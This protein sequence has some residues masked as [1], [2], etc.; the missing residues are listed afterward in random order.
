MMKRNGLVGLGV[1]GWFSLAASFAVLAAEP[2]LTE[3]AGQ[4]PAPEFALTDA[5]DRLHRLADYRGAPLIVNFWATWCAPC[6]AEMPALQRAWE[7]IEDEGIGLVAIN[8][9]EDADAVRA[10]LER[11]P[12]TFPLPLD[13]ET[14]VAPLW[15][16]RGLPTTFVLDGEGRL[17]Y[18]AVGEREWDDPRLLDRVRALKTP[19]GMEQAAR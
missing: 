7:A 6:R 17:I 9:G 8:V 13:R 10:F 11:Y 16:M 19:V 14:R 5:D 1:G 2:Q 12:V 15:P 3:V 18:E 4:P